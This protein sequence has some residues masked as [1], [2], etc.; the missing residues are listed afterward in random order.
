MSKK[1]EM[2]LLVPGPSGWEL[3]KHVADGGF[4]RAM[5]GG[6]MKIGE[7]TQ[8]PSG[9]LAMLFPVRAIQT[10]PFKAAST[11]PALFEDLAV[12]HAERLGIRPDPMAG[13][14]SDHFVVREDEESTVLLHAVLKSP[15]EGELPS[16]TPKEFDL[17]ARAYRADGDAVTA[18]KEL[19]RWVF[20]IHLGGKLLYAQATSLG[21]AVPNAAFLREIHLALGQLSIQGLKVTPTSVHVW[22]PEGELGE[23]G[24]LEDGLGVKA[25][26]EARPD[27]VIPKPVSR[28][29]PADV[30]AAR[31]ERQKRN[32]M[33]AGIAAVALLY[34]GA[35]GW[36]LFGLWQDVQLRDRLALEAG[37]VDEIA[38]E[39][40]E[41]MA[42]WDELQSVV[43][44]EQGPLEIMRNVAAAIPANSGVRLEIAD[45]GPDG[46]KLTAAAPQSAPLNAF[47]LGL[48]RTAD[49]SW[50]EWV[51]EAPNKTAQGWKMTI[52][53]APPRG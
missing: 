6:P 32:Q 42:K 18:W 43:E 19:G 5:E 14:L 8:L 45:M 41:Q 27:P 12:M 3:W 26:V 37:A 50:L 36:F 2:S 35:V 15:G 4:E 33:T 47:S 10:L 39:Y 40:Q 34:L 38:A 16:R 49:L 30:R 24:A 25:V 1:P 48:K 11:D 31:R 29:L 51:A 53:G 44:T 22:P 52:S 9:D 28:L 23:A 46:V 17:S 21:E 7:L 13:Q 20:A